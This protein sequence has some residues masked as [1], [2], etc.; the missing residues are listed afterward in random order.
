M[1]RAIIKRLY[2]WA[3]TAIPPAIGGVLIVQYEKLPEGIRESF[4]P[5]Q[6]IAGVIA[7]ACGLLT[8]S[9]SK[10]LGIPVAELQSWLTEKGLYAGKID[11]DLGP[12][13]IRSIARGIDDP[14]VFSDERL[15]SPPKPAKFKRP[16]GGKML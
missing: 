14:R 13:T 9:F 6:I 3:N 12:K 11:S 4:E 2:I 10:W 1:K 16:Q 5:W 15:V 8:F 7:I